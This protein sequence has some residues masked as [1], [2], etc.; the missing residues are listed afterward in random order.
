MQDEIV[1][2]LA[3]QLGAQLAIAE[4]RRAERR[5]APDSMDLY[6]QGMACINK[7]VRQNTWPGRK[8]SS[9]ARWHSIPA[10]STR[11]MVWRWPT[12][13]WPPPSS[14]ADR[15]ARLHAAEAAADQG[16]VARSPTT[17]GSIRSGAASRS[18]PI[19]RCRASPNTSAR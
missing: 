1:A 16:A 17:L 6:F 11:S 4:A 18:S 9:S 14:F 19:A 15:D 2:R 8:N 12:R 13:S 7:G 3:E 10:I 5:P